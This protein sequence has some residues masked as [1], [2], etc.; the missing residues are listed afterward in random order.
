MILQCS[1]PLTSMKL[2]AP[3]NHSWMRFGNH[4]KSV[5]PQHLAARCSS[6]K[7]HVVWRAQ[8]LLAALLTHSPSTLTHFSAWNVWSVIESSYQQI[9]INLFRC[10]CYWLYLWFYWVYNLL[11]STSFIKIFA[12]PY[13]LPSFPHAP[14]WSHHSARGNMGFIRLDLDEG[15]AENTQLSWN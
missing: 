7:P 15:G 1:L 8:C 12:L 14:K 13:S 3:A 10:S 6:G 9:I 2:P 11:S 5:H 4:I